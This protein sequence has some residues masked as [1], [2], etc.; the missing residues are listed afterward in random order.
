MSSQD[1]DW[2]NKYSLKSTK[3]QVTEIAEKRNK[4]TSQKEKMANY[5]EQKNKEADEI[6]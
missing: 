1:D 6:N 4:L 3:T 5:L 2:K